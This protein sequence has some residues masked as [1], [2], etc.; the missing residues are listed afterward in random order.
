MARC[1]AEETKNTP[2]RVNSVTPGPTR[3]A[4][5]AQAMPGEDPETL[6]HPSEVA[7]RIVPLASAALSETGML[8]DVREDR[9]KR[10]VMPA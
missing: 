4:M 9:F 6:P 2:L 3:T 10:Y 8:F 1:W 5:R 7:A